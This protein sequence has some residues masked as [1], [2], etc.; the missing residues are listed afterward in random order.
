VTQLEFDP[1]IFVTPNPRHRKRIPFGRLVENGLLDPGQLLYFGAQGEQTAR[2]LADGQLAFNGHRGSIHQIA[3]EI[4]SGPG[5][6]W[7]LWYFFNEAT[8]QREPIDKL[9]EIMRQE[10]AKEIKP[11]KAD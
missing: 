4:R 5:N 6:G 8:R 1:P 10:A 9:R 2:V 11:A 7:K 3:K